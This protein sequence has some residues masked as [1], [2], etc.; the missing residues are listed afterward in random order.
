MRLVRFFP[1]IR[2]RRA[3]LVFFF[4]FSQ[5]F[6]S[7]LINV[8]ATPLW[9]VHSVWTDM[10]RTA[11]SAVATA[12]HTYE[13]LVGSTTYKQSGPVEVE[14]LALFCELV[15]GVEHRLAGDADQPGK[16]LIQLQNQENSAGD[17]KGGNHQSEHDSSIG[18]REHAEAQENDH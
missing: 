9:G 13:L 14:A 11:H 2:T 4:P 12:L 6:A 16:R 8:V 3:R 15:Q 18:R 5:F 17:S 10:S 1:A 7:H